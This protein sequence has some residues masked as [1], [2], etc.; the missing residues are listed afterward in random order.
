MTH[1]DSGVSTDDI[2]TC[3]GIT[4]DASATGGAATAVS[5]FSC[6]MTNCATQCQ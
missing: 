1:P 2:N 6:V 3:A 4:G 5:L